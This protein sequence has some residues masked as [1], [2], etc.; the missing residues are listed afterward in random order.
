MVCGEG[1]GNAENFWAWRK[2]IGKWC[3][4]VGLFDG[5]VKSSEPR[6]CLRP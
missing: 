3:G 6:M 5:L 1:D 2:E 4:F